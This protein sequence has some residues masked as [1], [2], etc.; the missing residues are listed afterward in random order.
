MRSHLT[1]A[2]ASL[3]MLAVAPGAGASLLG[4]EITLSCSGGNVSCGGTKTVEP[5][6][7]M[8][9]VT[10]S[11]LSGPVVTFD[12]QSEAIVMTNVFNQD[13]LV[14]KTGGVSSG[15]VFAFSDLDWVDRPG[16]ITGATVSTTQGVTLRNNFALTFGPDSLTFDFDQD[17]SVV[18]RINSGSSITANLQVTH[19]PA[20]ATAGLLG[21]GLLGLGLAARQ[22]R[23]LGSRQ[24]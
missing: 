11:G 23:R 21:L 19:V 5:D 9:D 1:A 16:E 3:A 8:F 6:G 7:T 17:D 14:G 24:G 10:A 22:R 13:L 12:A 15:P 20:P 2:L 4:D 18:T